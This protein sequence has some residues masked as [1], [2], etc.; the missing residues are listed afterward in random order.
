MKL[1]I[2]KSHTLETSR[3]TLRIPNSEDIPYVFSATRSK[4]FNDGMLWEPPESEEELIDALKNNHIAWELGKGYAFTVTGKGSTRL[5]GRISIRKT[6]WLNVWNV[7]FWTH[8]QV[9]NQG[10]MTESLEAILQFGFEDLSAE[11]I[12][13]AC[14]TWNKASEKVLLKNKM[15]LIRYIA[16]GFK[17]KGIWVAEN[18]FAIGKKEWKD[19]I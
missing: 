2:P 7:G 17:K 5:L 13:A 15:S 6:E 14:A 16:E 9:Q 8:P 11:R 3:L 10:I 18:L 4:G 12:E 19:S 1:N